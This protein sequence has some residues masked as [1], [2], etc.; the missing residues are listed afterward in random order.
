MQKFIFLVLIFI[1][2]IILTGCGIKY[3]PVDARE[4]S[5]NVDEKGSKKY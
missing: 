2:S 3:K 5:P 4:V 1:S